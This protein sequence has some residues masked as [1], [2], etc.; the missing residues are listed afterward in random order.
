M[1]DQRLVTVGDVLELTLEAHRLLRS[2]VCDHDDLPSD[3][4]HWLADFRHFLAKTEGNRSGLRQRI[5]EVLEHRVSAL[6]SQHTAN[7][8]LELVDEY[9]D[10][11]PAI[12][13]TPRGD[14]S[15]EVE[16]LSRSM[17]EISTMQGSGAWDAAEPELQQIIRETADGLLQS[18]IVTVAVN[19]ENG[20]DLT[21]QQEAKADHF[22]SQVH[23]TQQAINAGQPLSKLPP[24]IPMPPGF[25]SDSE[26]TDLP[27]A[28]S[29]G[30]I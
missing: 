22:V 18:G 4:S 29:E 10:R 7:V 16:I 1:K 12:R 11:L 25:R 8:L 23:A 15:D 21:P 26:W 9:S 17:Y 28:P 14:E 2:C 19:R 13:Y 20:P 3:R 5:I 24:N 30:E 6:E 27:G